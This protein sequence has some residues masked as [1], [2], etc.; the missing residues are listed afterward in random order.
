MTPVA[1]PEGTADDA[2]GPPEPPEP[3]EP[4]EPPEPPPPPPPE[5]PE[6]AM[7]PLVTESAGAHSYK[8]ISTGVQTVSPP[9]VPIIHPRLK[10]VL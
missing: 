5:P 7:A 2:T 4:P 8:S 10:S 3:Q 9:S 6:E 1:T